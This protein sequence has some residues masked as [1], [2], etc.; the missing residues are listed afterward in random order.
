MRI[1]NRL[2]AAVVAILVIAAAFVVVSE[3]VVAQVFKRDPW[4]VPHDR[5]LR[6][7]RQDTWADSDSV[8]QL[9][10]ALLVVGAVLLILQLVRRR[11]TTVPLDV[12]GRSAVEVHRRSLERSLAR[13]AERLDAVDKASVDVGGDHLQVR[14]TTNRRQAPNLEAE[15]TQSLL[16]ALRRTHPVRE[17]DIRVKVSRRQS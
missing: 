15:I 16:D 13:T 11:P 10:V 4:I 3:V 14:A 2:L 1:V 9:A 12:G 8:L 7:A 17:P 6:S 5:W